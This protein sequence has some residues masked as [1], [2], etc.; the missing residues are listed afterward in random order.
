MPSRKFKLRP[1][2]RERLELRWTGS[3]VNTEVLLDGA[4]LHTFADRAAL[5]RGQLIETPKGKELFVQYVGGLAITY[6]GVHVP[7]SVLDPKAAA[8][9]AAG[10][11]YVLA[12]M[13]LV[14]F[15]MRVSGGGASENAIGNLLFGI[16]LAVLGFFT[17]RGSRK[18]L[19]AT[20]VLLVIDVVALFVL[21]KDSGFP[22][23]G[24]ALRAFFLYSLGRSLNR[25]KQAPP[26]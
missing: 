15:A 16:L 7:G 11:T 10:V 13:N 5:M 8:G 20:M 25:M 17:G 18:T 9:S 26:K 1:D 2:G 24:L 21:S 19:G 22:T 12:A 4:V 6:N 14:A 3:F 23:F